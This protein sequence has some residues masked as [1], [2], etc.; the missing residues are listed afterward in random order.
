MNG[1]MQEL[2][3]PL[4]SKIA[5]NAYAHVGWPQPFSGTHA[6][7]NG[8]PSKP[9]TRASY[10]GDETQPGGTAATACIMLF[11]ASPVDERKS[12]NMDEPNV[13]KFAC[14]SS[15]PSKRTVAKSCMPSVAKMK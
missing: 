8:A 7:D 12:V 14:S 11:H 5:K 15:S 13:R 3:I 9:H 1:K 10:S 4:T 6:G 2:A